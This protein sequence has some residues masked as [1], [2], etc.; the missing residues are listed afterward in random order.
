MVDVA[1]KF[2][3]SSI[4]QVK[5]S[6]KGDLNKVETWPS[7]LR[8]LSRWR[9]AVDL[10]LLRRSVEDLKAIRPNLNN[11]NKVVAARLL[12][13]SDLVRRY[14]GTV[15]DRFG[16]P[17]SGLGVLTALARFTPDDLTISK[18]NRN[19]LVTS[20]GI[21]FVVTRLEERRLVARRSHPP[22]GRAVLVQ[23]TRRGRGV[24]DLLID[25]TAL[26]DTAALVE[27]DAL[28]LSL[29]DNLL[30][31]VQC[32]ME[33]ATS[34]RPVAATRGEASN[35]CS[36]VAQKRDRTTG[37]GTLRDGSPRARD[38]KT[39]TIRLGHLRA[40]GGRNMAFEGVRFARDRTAH[41]RPRVRSCLAATQLGNQRVVRCEPITRATMAQTRRRPDETSS[42]FRQ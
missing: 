36:R 14:D 18:L 22:D 32:G 10:S 38:S 16:V 13:V 34:P 24:A 28:E 33:S 31:H 19:I 39:S 41:N 20:G 12:P 15:F 25:A 29:A 17:Q 11:E 8:E 9:G 1:R 42:N 30:I 35:S 27:L 26:A 5:T 40:Q 2:H 4:S 3:G 6:E 7:A 37:D 23:L 21:T